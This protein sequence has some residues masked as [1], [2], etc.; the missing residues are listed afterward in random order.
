LNRSAFVRQQNEIASI[1]Q[2]TQRLL[3]ASFG[4]AVVVSLA[5]ALLATVYAGRL[6]TRIQQQRLREGEYARDLQRSRT[7][8]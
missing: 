1:Y 7:M 8:V 3:W 2:M 6:E 5:I 4:L